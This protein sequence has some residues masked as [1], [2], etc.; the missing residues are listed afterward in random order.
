MSKERT[1]LLASG[2]AEKFPVGPILPIPGPTLPTDVA[3]ALIASLNVTPP[4][5]VITIEPK[6]NMNKYKN[7]NASK[8]YII[9]LETGSL[10]K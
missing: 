3:T 2:S 4:I 6:V 1:H 7:M 9:L 5:A 8:L 10:F